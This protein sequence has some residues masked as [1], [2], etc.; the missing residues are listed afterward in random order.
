MESMCE[1]GKQAHENIEREMSEMKKAHEKLE[2]RFYTAY[3]GGLFFVILQ[4]ITIL[5]IYMKK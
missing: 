1:L 5:M 3:V 2:N 4:L